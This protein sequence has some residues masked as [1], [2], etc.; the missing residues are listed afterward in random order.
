M[1]VSDGVSLEFNQ[2]K[3]IISIDGNSK[4][5]DSVIPEKIR[6]YVF[7]KF[8]AN[9]ITDWEI[10]NKTQQVSLDNEIDLI[11]TMSGVFIRLDE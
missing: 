9:F 3:E 7:K 10:D 5:P 8:P 6:N 4:L 1:I 11:F 2:K